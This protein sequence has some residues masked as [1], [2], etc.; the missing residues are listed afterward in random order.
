MIKNVTMPGS[1]KVPGFFMPCLL[2][3]E[4]SCDVVELVVHDM[5]EALVGR[6]AVKR[7]EMFD[8]GSHLDVVEVVLIDGAVDAQPAAV[9][10][11]S[12]PRMLLPDMS[13]EVVDGLRL[14]VTAHQTD[15]RHQSVVVSNQPVDDIRGQ[16]VAEVLGKITAVASR[17]MTRTPRDVDGQRRLVRNLLKHDVSV[18]VLQH[19]LLL[20]LHRLMCFAAL[21]ERDGLCLRQTVD[22]GVETAVGLGLTGL[23]EVAHP[24]EVSD[25]TRQIVDILGVADGAFL[26]VALVDMT[27]VVADG[28]RDVIC[29]VVAALVSGDAEELAILLLRQVLVEVHVQC[30]ATG[31]VL[32]VGSTMKL[33]LVEDAQRVVLHHIEITVVAVARHEIA[34]LTIPFGVLDTDVLGRNHLAVEHHLFAAVL[35]V[36]L[37]NRTQDVL[38]EVLIVVVGRDLQSHELSGFHESVDA[39][40]E[41]LSVDVDISG[42]KERQHAVSLELLEILI[43]SELYLM[44]EVDDMI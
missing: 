32:D 10:P 2:L 23:G 21:T 3:P 18:N 6:A 34:V 30:G 38:Y 1:Q 26:E 12:H 35:L 8:V 24:L 25:D 43:V 29:E 13:C 16:R 15:T 4:G 41:I 39:N 40:G 20:L 5:I 27:A 22:A 37:F 17:T 19:C 44:A 11:Y 42:I 33:E 28:I 7:A 31:E 36:V 14:S 9:P